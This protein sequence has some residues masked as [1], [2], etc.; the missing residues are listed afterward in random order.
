[1][2]NSKLIQIL[3]Q[4][5][6]GGLVD[7]DEIADLVEDDPDTKFENDIKEAIEFIEW[8]TDN[9]FTDHTDA[10]P[11][12]DFESSDE[13]TLRNPKTGFV[14][15]IRKNYEIKHV[16]YDYTIVELDDLKKDLNEAGLDFFSFIG[17]SLNQ[18]LNGIHKFP[19]YLTGLIDA[20]NQWNGLYMQSCR[21]IESPDS[22]KNGMKHR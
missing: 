21:W 4:R 6:P 3:R 19:D 9:G 16:W 5:D 20:L 11:K 15:Y 2:K 22:L 1:M 7:P 14:V 10:N 13:I 8:L 17:S 12:S 18:E